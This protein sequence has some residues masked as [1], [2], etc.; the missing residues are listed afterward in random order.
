[1]LS[2]AVDSYGFVTMHV[3]IYQPAKT[4]MQSGLG[5]T[6]E[7]V[8]EFAAGARHLE[9]LMGWTSSDDTRSQV[10]LRFP[11]KDEAI[12]HAKRHGY[13]YTV[14]EPKQRKPRLKAYSDNFAFTRQGP[15]T[16]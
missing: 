1:M 8:L 12:A 2:E 5:N 15:W 14:L 9:P 13:M 6:R 10:Q 11:S 3:R 7:W 4:A 16:H